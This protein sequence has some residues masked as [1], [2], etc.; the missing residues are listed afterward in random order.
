MEK[1]HCGMEM[2]R[3]DQKHSI[4][5]CILVPCHNEK[6]SDHSRSF[7]NVLL[8]QFRTGHT[9]KRTIC[10]MCNSTRQQRF[11]RS[12]RTV[13]QYSF[14]LSNSESVKQFRMLDRQ[15][16]DLENRNVNDATVEGKK[17]P[18]LFNFSNLFIQ[19]TDH[20]VC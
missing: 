15:F 5:Y 9:N 12:R 16:N 10:M 3:T 8:Y 1:P 7:T 17:D 11:S 4:V 19:S 14:R 2:I 20:I 13:Q 18:N 6:F